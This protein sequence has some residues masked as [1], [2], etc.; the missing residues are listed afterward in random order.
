MEKPFD[1][2]DL[3][4]RLK[5]RGLPIAEQAAEGVYEDLK[6]WLNDSAVIHENSLVKSLVPLLLGVADQM[7][8]EQLDKIDGQAG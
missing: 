4:A 7:V 1:L 5:S 3:V 6:G 8:K 2:K